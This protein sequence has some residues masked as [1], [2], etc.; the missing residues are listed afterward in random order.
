MAEERSLYGNPMPGA[1]PAA[2]KRIREL[3]HS[4]QGTLRMLRAQMMQTGTTGNPK[5]KKRVDAAQV[6]LQ[7]EGLEP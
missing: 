4:L 2:H 7:Q 3:E 1:L 5:L 6:T